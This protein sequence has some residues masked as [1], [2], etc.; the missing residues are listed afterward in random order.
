MDFLLDKRRV[1]YKELRHLI[2]KERYQRQMEI[3]TSI[4]GIGKLTAIRLILEWGDLRRFSSA[5]QLSSY[6]GMT[7]S[8]FS[9]G[10]SVR[11]GHITGQ[12]NRQTRAWLIE[13]AWTA[14]RYDPVLHKK[15]ADIVERTRSPKIAIVA[16]GRKLAVRLRTCLL[17]NELY[18]IGVV[19]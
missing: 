17:S 12:G 4:P 10:D 14:I 7:P 5:K 1:V 2:K 6:T 18:Q 11:K 15:Y 9:T 19:K 8:E 3:Y 16:V 13:S